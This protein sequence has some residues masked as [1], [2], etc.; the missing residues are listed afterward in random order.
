M[1]FNSAF[2]GLT[3]GKDLFKLRHFWSQRPCNSWEAGNA[4]HSVI[5]WDVLVDI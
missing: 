3:L 2:K 1:G 5:Y 4:V